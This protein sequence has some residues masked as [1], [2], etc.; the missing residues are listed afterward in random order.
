MPTWEYSYR[1]VMAFRKDGAHNTEL[2]SHFLKIALIYPLA[3]VGM[4]CVAHNHVEVR[5]SLHIT[6]PGNQ[7]QVGKLALSIFTNW[8]ISPT[9]R[10]TFVTLVFL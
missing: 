7:A 2:V 8:F 9:H 6:G 5:S 4:G 3:V 1:V 10:H